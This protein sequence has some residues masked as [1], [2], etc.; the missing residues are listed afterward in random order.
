M[1]EEKILWEEHKSSNLV[2]AVIVA[3]GSSTR[4]GKD[5]IFL[6]I[7]GV[8]VVVRTMEAFQKAST[9]SEIIIVTRED[10]I[11]KI[12]TFAEQKS[13]TKVVSVVCGGNNRQASVTAGILETSGKI[14][15]YCI[16]DGARP[17]ITPEMIDE[18]NRKAFTYGCAAV[19]VK[20]KDTIKS[21]DKDGMFSQ[22]IDR[23]YL[24]AV[25]TPQV[26]EAKKYQKALETACRQGKS[27]TDDCQLLENIG[28]KIYMLNGSYDNIKITTPEDVAVAEAHIKS[29][30]F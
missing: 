27:F 24:Y 6:D 10:S 22:T 19:G 7:L 17:L 15:Y 2:S 25:Q 28:E 21:V 18:V 16:H 11:E 26:F 30:E 8:P 4:M 13:F 9:I 12:K 23:E 5:K 29:V 20:L 14:G 3:A 1:L